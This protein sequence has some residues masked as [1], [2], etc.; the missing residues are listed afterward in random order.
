[1][2]L[3]NISGEFSSGVE[4]TCHYL[5][6]LFNPETIEYIIGEYLKILAKNGENPD[7]S[8]Q[9]FIAVKDKKNSILISW[10]CSM[11]GPKK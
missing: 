3:F 5:K 7:G 1:M 4:V 8:L 2:I 10:G 6:G 9:D 11:S